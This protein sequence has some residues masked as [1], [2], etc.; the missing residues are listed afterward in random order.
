MNF[1]STLLAVFKL[2][3]IMLNIYATNQFY[4]TKA[5]LNLSTVTILSLVGTPFT[6]ALASLITIHNLK[7][8]RDRNK[9]LHTIKTTF[10]NTKHKELNLLM[11]NHNITRAIVV[12][13]LKEDILKKSSINFSLLILL[14]TAIGLLISPIVSIILIIATYLLSAV[15]KGLVRVSLDKDYVINHMI[16]LLELELRVGNEKYVTRLVQKCNITTNAEE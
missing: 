12:N 14:V 15:I 2:L 4:S 5:I 9:L 7:S 16:D 10:D 11:D 3:L 8:H 6:I 1:E 13:T